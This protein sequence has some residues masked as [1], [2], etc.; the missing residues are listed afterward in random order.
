MLIVGLA[1]GLAI[2][3]QAFIVKPYEIPSRSMVPTLEVDQ[4][5]LVNRLAYRFGDPEV[6]DVVVFHPPAGAQSGGAQ[7]GV[8]RSADEPCPEG[9]DREAEDTFVKR[10]VAGPGDRI[11]V[12]DGHPVV[13]GELMDDEEFI[14]PC[15]PNGSACD[16]PEEI[17]V[18]PGQYFMM[19][20]NRGASDDS[21]FWGPVPEDNFI[22]K[23]FV[24]YW[25]PSRIG[26]V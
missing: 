14:Q 21:R 24:T 16:L 20:D 2:A 26:G 23:A 3:I 10:I 18:P 4:K 12:D 1:V 25:P 7:C 15:G 19:G 11:R 5:I 17:T 9:V 22:G 6:G 8:Q 13:N